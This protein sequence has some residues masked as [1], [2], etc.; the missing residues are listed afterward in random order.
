LLIAAERRKRLTV[1]KT[2]AFLKSMQK[3]RLAVE[4]TFDEHD[5][6][7][8][9]RRHALTVYDS[10]YLALAMR[11]SLP[12]ATLDRKLAAA[13]KDEGVTLIA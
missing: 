1:A 6:I 12:L 4:Q 13:A 7:H 9:A 5:A 2:N 8:L 10:S 11:E 3:L